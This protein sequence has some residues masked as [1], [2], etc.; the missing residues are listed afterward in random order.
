MSKWNTALEVRKHLRQPEGGKHQGYSSAPLR[1]EEKNYMKGKTYLKQQLLKD[2]FAL[3]RYGK[4]QLI[5]IKE[6]EI[7]KIITNKEFTK[8]QDRQF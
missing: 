5:Q 7:Y 2:P 6:K 1:I 4:R 8:E 3:K